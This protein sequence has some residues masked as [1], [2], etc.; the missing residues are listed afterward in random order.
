MKIDFDQKLVT[1]DG[2]PLLG[3][4]DSNKPG[5][6]RKPLKLKDVCIMALLSPLA[7]KNIDGEKK[8]E[9]WENAKLIKKGGKINFTTETIAELKKLINDVYPSPMVVG[10]AWVMLEAGEEAAEKKSKKDS[11]LKNL[12]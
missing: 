6:K 5:E 10:Q 3:L 7:S 4:P 12:S 2:K 11:V 8:L 9:R 1:L